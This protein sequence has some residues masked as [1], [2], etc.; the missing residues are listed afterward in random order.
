MK[1]TEQTEERLT[2]ANTARDKVDLLEGCRVA[3]R[4]HA[5]VRR[6]RKS[7]PHG[8]TQP[9]RRD[10]YMI[11]GAENGADTNDPLQILET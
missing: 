2:P 7:G 4:V 8:F 11:L 3:G 9:R 5:F 6:R 10:T 1:T